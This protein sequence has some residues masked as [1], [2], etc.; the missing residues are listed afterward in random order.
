M[1]FGDSKTIISNQDSIHEKLT[2]V[3]TRH[4]AH[5]FQKPYSQHTL[6][7]FAAVKSAVEQHTGNIILD[8]CCG[9]GEST[10]NL[11]HKY[12][13]ALVIGVD[14][15]GHRIERNSEFIMPDNGLLVQADLNDFYRLVAQQQW[16]IS[17][18]YVLYPNPWPKAKHLQR[19]WHG[20]AIFPTMIKLAPETELRSNWLIYLQE[21]QVALKLA[22]VESSITELTTSEPITPFERKYLA[23]GQTCWQLIAKY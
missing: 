22:G 16:S 2:E 7:A 15:S 5:P 19:R 1:S 8:A 17:K 4:L 13:E 21:F 23:S 12:P 14:K 20:C 9:V 3:V 11:A 18:H 6:D 10:K